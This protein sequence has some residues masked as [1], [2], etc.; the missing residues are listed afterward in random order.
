[1]MIWMLAGC[2]EWAGCYRARESREDLIVLKDK[3]R[4]RGKD[5]DLPFRIA[6]RI[7]AEPDLI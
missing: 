3:T 4:M 6:P 1:M 5:R 7:K 2:E